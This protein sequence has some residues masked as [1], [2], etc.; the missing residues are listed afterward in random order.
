MF[1][2]EENDFQTQQLYNRSDDLVRYYGV[3][4]EDVEHWRLLV[5]VKY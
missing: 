1:V 5:G 4:F 2:P 3:C